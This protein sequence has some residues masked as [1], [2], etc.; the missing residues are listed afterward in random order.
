M[1][2]PDSFSDR[3]RDNL[4]NHGEREG[5]SPAVRTVR[6]TKKIAMRKPDEEG[7]L[8]HDATHNEFLSVRREGGREVSWSRDYCNLDAIIS[9]GYRVKSAVATRF[10]IWARHP[11]NV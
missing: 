8:H 2:V 4:T 5:D 9:V 7:E 1:N 10:R 6:K 3:R 11:I